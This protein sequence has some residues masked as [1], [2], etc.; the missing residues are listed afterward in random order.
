M[1]KYRLEE[2]RAEMELCNVKYKAKLNALRIDKSEDLVWTDPRLELP[3]YGYRYKYRGIPMRSK[4]EVRWAMFFDLLDWK[5]SYEP[6]DF[7]VKGYQVDF[8]LPDLQNGTFVENKDAYL[9]KD[10]VLKP[11]EKVA[12]D[13][14]RRLALSTNW[15][16][17]YCIICGD[18]CGPYDEVIHSAVGA[19]RG[20]QLSKDSTCNVWWFDCPECGMDLCKPSSG[21]TCTIC[22]HDM[23][24]DSSRMS[25]IAVFIQSELPARVWQSDT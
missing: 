22:G 11:P 6:S 2:L 5:W 15:H 4:H 23:E 7:C 24:L 19:Y 17:R 3:P 13:K 8:F 18:P 21:I 14:L 12:I 1:D 25:R 16:Y 20:A 9:G 10:G